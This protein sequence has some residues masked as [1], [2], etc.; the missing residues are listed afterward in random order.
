M[1][2]IKVKYGE[3]RPSGE[4]YCMREFEI[5]IT[6]GAEMGLCCKEDEYNWIKMTKEQIKEIVREEFEGVK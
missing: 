3:K 1:P 4:P 6:R 2:E 5:E